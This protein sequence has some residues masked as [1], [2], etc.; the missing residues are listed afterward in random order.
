MFDPLWFSLQKRA[1]AALVAIW[2]NGMRWF[3][4][5]FSF[6]RN[7]SEKSAIQLFS[8]RRP[9]LERAAFDFKCPKLQAAIDA[10]IR[11]E[12]PNRQQHVSRSLR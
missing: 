7:V 8:V 1:L 2:T 9:A 6:F 4:V 3:A 10:A 11:R 12:R 5:L